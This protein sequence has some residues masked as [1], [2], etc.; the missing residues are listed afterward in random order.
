M[1]RQTIAQQRA[2]HALTQIE[3]MKEWDDGHLSS[4]IAGFPAM[5]LMNGFGQTCAFYFSKGDRMKLV[6]DA[7]ENWL[8]SADRPYSDA[9]NGLMRAITSNNAARYRLAQAEAMAYLDWLKKF[10]KAFLESEENNS[11]S[12]QEAITPTIEEEI[13]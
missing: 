7:L 10:A 12:E 2:R 9:K 13:S 4:H 11:G 6:Y 8:T 3:T 1:S 5:I